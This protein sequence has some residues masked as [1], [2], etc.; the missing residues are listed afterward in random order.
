MLRF[1]DY[2]DLGGLL[3]ALRRRADEEFAALTGPAREALHRV[4]ATIV[5]IDPT[6]ER[7]IVESR[8]LRAQFDDHP[9]SQALTI[10]SCMRVCWWRTARPTVL[11]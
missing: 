9:P 5:R 8:V 4:L 2:E 10:P 1:R 11:R 7:L 6:D 3:G